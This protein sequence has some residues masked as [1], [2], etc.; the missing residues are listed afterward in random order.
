MVNTEQDHHWNEHKVVG[1]YRT[2]SPL[3]GAQCGW[4]IQNKITTGLNTMW[5]VNAEQ[6][7]HWIEHNVVSLYIIVNKQEIHQ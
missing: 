2:K 1:Q 4:S 6:D 7:H 5:L 3:E